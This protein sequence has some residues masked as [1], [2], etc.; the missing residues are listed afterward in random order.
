MEEK[1]TM[2]SDGYGSWSYCFL[3]FLNLMGLFMMC[4]L[5]LFKGCNV[6]LR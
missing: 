1:A 2:N 4:F 5:L 6:G 3:S